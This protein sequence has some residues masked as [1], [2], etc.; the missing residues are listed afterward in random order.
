MK[1]EKLAKTE[2]KRTT[3]RSEGTKNSKAI[4]ITNV[5]RKTKLLET[6]K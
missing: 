5:Q 2:N 1:N 3:K 6:K 4:Y